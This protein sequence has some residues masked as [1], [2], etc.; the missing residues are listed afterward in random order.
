[1]NTDGVTLIDGT[2]L[3]GMGGF[4]GSIDLGSNGLVY[5]TG[6]GIVNPTT[7]P[8]SQIATLPLFDFYDSGV[9]GFGVATAA[10]PSLGKEFLMLDNEAGTSA[11]GLVRYDLNTYT[12]DTVLDMP[13]S[14]SS[15]FAGWTML[16]F[17]QDGLALLSYAQGSSQLIL[18]RGP[19][20]SP[21][22]LK[23]SSAASLTSSSVTSIAHGSGNTIL[24]LTGSNFQPGVAVTWNGKYRTTTIVDSSH[25]TVDIPAS[26]LANAGTGALVATNPG[27]PPSDTLNITID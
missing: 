22:L 8:P 4:S 24:T 26:D 12:P 10:D 13:Q 6:G 14:A 3:D 17:G 21:Q 25:V 27:A 18:L 23:K 20:V 2:T 11:Y 9:N 5:G 1:V 15:F 7:T 19:F 16:R